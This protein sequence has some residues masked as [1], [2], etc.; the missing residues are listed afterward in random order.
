ML[1]VEKKSFF[2]GLDRFLTRRAN[3]ERSRVST[4][5]SLLALM[6]LMRRVTEDAITD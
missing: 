5:D 3:R 4:R 1:M 6:A 2:S